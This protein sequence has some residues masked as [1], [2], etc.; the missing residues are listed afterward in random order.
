[1]DA[2]RAG[3]GPPPG[4]RTYR[5][6]AHSMFDPELY[7]DKERKCSAGANDPIDLLRNA[8]DLDDP[9]VAADGDEI[10][11][12]VEDAVTFAESPRTRMS[13]T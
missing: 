13:L 2:I 8:L 6:R 12:E 5:F 11:A 1:M 10:A 4:G 3:G 9:D 7:R